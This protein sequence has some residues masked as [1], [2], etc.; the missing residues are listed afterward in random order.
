MILKTL[1]KHLQTFLEGQ[2]SH[3][4]DGGVRP[5]IIAQRLTH[6]LESNRQ[7]NIVPD[8]FVVALHGDVLTTVL[9]SHATLTPE[10]EA[11]LDALVQSAHLHMNFYPQVIF[12]GDDTLAVH[13]VRVRASYRQ[14]ELT[15]T[16]EL[17]Q[18]EATPA[19]TTPQEA[20]LIIA[21]NNHFSLNQPLVNIGRHSDNHIALNSA[22][23]SR[24][25]CQIRLR[26]GHYILYDL[27]SK[28][29]TFVNGFRIQEHR[30]QTGDV[31]ECGDIQIVYVEYN[32]DT[33]AGDTQKGLTFNHD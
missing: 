28:S 21:G 30:L 15:E 7:G 19:Q 6:A 4:V 3:F 9:S 12:V 29:G 26:F 13:E 17:D 1:E 24:Q 22:T 23:V 33:H 8:Q 31:I 2:L 25:H 10:L 32:V 16:Q 5:H 27:Q 18:F 20:H 11:Q 14:A